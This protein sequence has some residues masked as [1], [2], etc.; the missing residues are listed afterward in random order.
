M[1][2][3]EII[4]IGS[5]L[6]D[7]SVLNT[8]AQY[9]ARRATELHIEVGHQS[10]CPDRETEIIDALDRAFERSRLILVTGGLG[11]T[12]DDVTREAVAHYFGCGLKYHP[13][14][15]RQVVRHFRRSSRCVPPITR[16][17]AYL[18]TVA[19]P[20]LN[21]AGIAVGFYVT[22][23]RRLLVVLPGVPREVTNMYERCVRSLIQ[24]EIR[25][26]PIRHLLIAKIV[27]LNEP[28][29]MRQ[30]GRQFFKLGDFDFGIYPEIAEVMIRIKS[31]E[32][33]LITQLRRE[34]ERRFG[35]RL[36]S[37]ED[38]PLARMIGRA[39]RRRRLS[40]AVAESCTGGLLSKR[41]TDVAGASRYFKGGTV[42][43]SDEIKRQ[44]LGVPKA[45][46][47]RHG[48]VSIEVARGMAQGVRRRY[49]ASVGLSVTGI[50]GPSG[51]SRRKPVGLVYIGLAAESGAQTLECRFSG[52]RSKVRLQAAA[53]ALEILWR[54]LAT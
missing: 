35:P 49:G 24:K 19:K 21:R 37:F 2:S 52:D 47:A 17:E 53:R 15:Y 7:G 33:T 28:Q 20:L 18:P 43:Y 34:L 54:W 38:V 26:R 8:N 12:P 44:D 48:A 14:Q 9:L 16:R 31:S 10:S 22:R 6:L 41:I 25:D 40:L 39:L 4:T 30:L 45:L 13:E 11:A 5:E 1:P 27:G 42:A 36:Y 3:C 50:A 32:K 29:V 23:H 46:L 51:G